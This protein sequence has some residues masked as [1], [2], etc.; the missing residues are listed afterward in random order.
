MF[1]QGVQSLQFLRLVKNFH[2]LINLI[3]V[4]PFSELKCLLRNRKQTCTKDF[5]H[6]LKMLVFSSICSFLK[7][8]PKYTDSDSS[9]FLLSFQGCISW[10]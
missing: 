6:F 3:K 1:I 2:E 10:F 5:S 4:G 9:F 8:K 7:P